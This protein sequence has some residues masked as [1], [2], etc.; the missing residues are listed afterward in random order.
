MRALNVKDSAVSIDTQHSTATNPVVEI[1]MLH[2]L[3]FGYLLFINKA[4]YWAFPS[5]LILR[6]EPPLFAAGSLKLTINNNI[7]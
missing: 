3:V 6:Y 5:I 7:S 4:H 1:V 2:N